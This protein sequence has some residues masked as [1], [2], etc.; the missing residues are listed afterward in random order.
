M[1]LADGLG[2]GCHLHVS[3][4][5]DGRNLLGAIPTASSGITGE[6]SA[7]MAGVL[8]EC[9]ALAALGGA[10]PISYRRLAPNRW[11]GAYVCWGVENREAPLRFIRGARR[12]G[13][14]A[15]TPS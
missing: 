5:R 6:G 1:A 9:R 8:R 2:N 7:F 3:L 12:R 14:T 15:S 13:R 10:C 11:T 4:W